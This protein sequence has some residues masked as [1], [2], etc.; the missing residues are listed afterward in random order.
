M[1]SIKSL[2]TASLLASALTLSACGNESGG[3]TTSAEPLP[4]VDAPEGTQWR[5][6]VA[7]TEEN[8]YVIG[9]PDAPIKLVEYAALTCGACAAFEQEAYGEILEKYV[10]DGRVSFEIRNFLISPYGIPLGLITRCGSCL[11]YTSPS[12][13]DRG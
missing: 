9:N 11:L 3:A 8:G 1:P 7:K 2:F 10:S 6:T 12:P 13:R 4:T 5:D